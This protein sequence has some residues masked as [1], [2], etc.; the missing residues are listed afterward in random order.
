MQ[1]LAKLVALGTQPLGWVLLGMVLAL[2]ALPRRPALARRALWLSL[3]LLLALG[4]RPLV[5]PLLAYLEGQYPES[6]PSAA[7]PADLAGVVVLGGATA[8]GFLAQAHPQPL[9]EDGAE[10][11]TA[12]AALARQHPQW[13]L[14]FTGGE[15]QLLGSGPSEA[16]R[17]R[18][19][20]A[21]LGLAP[22]S[23]VLESAS[24][25]THENAVFSARMPGVDPRQRW[26]L[27]T[28]AWHMPRAMASFQAAGWNV[29]AYPVDQRSAPEVP[30]TEYSLQE[31]A[32]LWQLALHEILGLWAYR[33][34]GR[35]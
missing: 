31:G 15:G 10:R 26:L 2:W 28:S 8:P 32:R 5:N 33:L 21:Q 24:R 4:W 9:L 34:L 13:T 17:A 6:P 27:V 19:V 7:L 14:I 29:L 1:L 22:A 25:N 20:F 30:W 16:E 23:L 3:A 12:A 18:A 11:M 35:A